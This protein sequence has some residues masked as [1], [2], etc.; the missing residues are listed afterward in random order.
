[1]T[2]KKQLQFL[3][4]QFRRFKTQYVISFSGLF[5]ATTTFLCLF[6]FITYHYS[7]DRFHRQASDI[8]RLNTLINLPEQQNKYAATAY[9]AGPEIA[10]Q[11]PEVRHMIRL[12][13]MPGVV[14]YGTTRFS[15]GL[16][17]FVDSAFLEVFSFDVLAGEAGHALMA[18]NSIVLRQELAE[19]Y[20]PNEDPLGKTL[21]A[22]ILGQEQALEIT[23][24]VKD[25]P[26][27]SSIRF[28]MLVNIRQIAGAFRPG[29]A[30]LVPGLFT[31]FELQPQASQA[32]FSG[33]LQDFVKTKLPEQLQNVMSFNAMPMRD[34]YFEH[35]YQFDTELK[36]NRNTL[37]SLLVL[38][39]ITLIMAVINYVNISTTLGIRRSKEIAVRKIMGSTPGQIARQQYLDSLTVIGLT[40][41]PAALLSKALL[42][43]LGAWLDL[44]LTAGPLS[45]GVFW[46]LLLAFALLLAVF[47]AA[48][49]AL[50][51]SRLSITE[52]LKRNVKLIS[53][54]FDPKKAL[55]GFQFVIAVFFLSSAWIVYHQLQF[56]RQKDPGFTK[57]QVLMVDVAGPDM[58]AQIPAIKQA[59]LQVPG[60]A[61][62]SA[63]TTGIY[64][65]HTQANFSVPSDSTGNGF[66][67]D[68]NYVDADFLETYQVHLLSGRNFSAGINSDHGNAF[69]LN[70]TA[71]RRL[72]FQDVA[73]LVGIPLQKVTRD[74]MQASVIGIVGD[75]HFQS[76]YQSIAPMVWQIMDE[77]PK[78][79]LAIRTQGDMQSLLASL[80]QKW[81]TLNTGSAF[82]FTFL[83]EAM[84]NAYRSEQHMGV[85]IRMISAILLFIT[86]SGLYAMMLFLIEQ[87]T[88]EIG[89]RKTLGAGNWNIQV[90]LYRQ[91][92][93]IPIG[94]MVL[95]GSL[96]YWAGNKWLENFAYRIDGQA[97]FI[98]VAALIC[99][100]LGWLSI[101]MLSFRAGQLN[102][103]EVLR[104]VQS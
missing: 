10:A 9:E 101:A 24:V 82:D 46:L 12:R 95:G 91:Y 102:P 67:I 38:A 7:F 11:Y 16:I 30:S 69:I 57:E 85:F 17:S 43:V 103:V 23:A 62:L 6:H 73:A 68:I 34:M 45:S 5:L 33:H 1:M 64:G 42:P 96:A 53:L 94:G 83:D 51:L 63:S 19:K 22:T 72:G 76:M 92:I 58:Q 20:F 93:L 59:L 44:E 87:K 55:L 25:P 90:H 75:Y 100:L 66:L 26:P 36:G 74:T 18:P 77:A 8:V 52:V 84:D 104:E 48:Y 15:E 81:N 71:A 79:V 29:Y 13:A 37:L 56:L 50:I 28:D 54:R 49:P 97:G 27:N 98:I 3:F 80:E 65:M 61:S 41:I 70:E 60:V 88:M 39:I 32:D 78:N 99:L 89:I 21:Q 2:G 14:E 4:R 35:G 86:C 31:Y 47:A 40:V